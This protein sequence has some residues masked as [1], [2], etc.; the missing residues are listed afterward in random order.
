MLGVGGT[1]AEQ[2]VNG[3]GNSEQRWQ[4]RR[5][6]DRGN[7]KL[8]WAILEVRGIGQSFTGAVG[9]RGGGHRVCSFVD[10]G[11]VTGE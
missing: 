4:W 2:R 7:I 1:S 3:G 10:G 11:D 5:F 9:R 6:C 8:T